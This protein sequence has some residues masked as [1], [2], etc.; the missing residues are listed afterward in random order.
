MAVSSGSPAFDAAALNSEMLRMQDLGP[1]TVQ[2]HSTYGPAALFAPPVGAAAARAADAA[3]FR[4]L[5]A[6]AIQSGASYSTY[7]NALQSLGVSLYP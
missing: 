6:A 1:A 5:I 4:R 2:N 7:L 3:H